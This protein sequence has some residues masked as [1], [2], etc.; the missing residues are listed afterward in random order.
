M[1]TRQPTNGRKKS[2]GM[3]LGEMEKDV[4]L[5][6]GAPHVLQARANSIG[7]DTFEGVEMPH[8]TSLLMRELNAMLVKVD[9]NVM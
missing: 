6:H 5:S 4:L 1:I 7:M 2:G 9:V 3:R 8:A